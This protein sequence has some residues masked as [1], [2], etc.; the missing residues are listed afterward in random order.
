MLIDFKSW[1]HDLRLQAGLVFSHLF[2]CVRTGIWLDACRILGI[3]ILDD[4]YASEGDS[5]CGLRWRGTIWQCCQLL[6]IEHRLPEGGWR[7]FRKL[8]QKG[9]EL[10]REERRH[11]QIARQIESFRALAEAHTGLRLSDA[12]LMRFLDFMRSQISQ[13]SH[14]ID[15]EKE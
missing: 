12:Q 4:S 5:C 15:T 6:G 7:G 2:W 14:G 13:Q 11:R 9:A 10:R 8:R 3:G 1:F